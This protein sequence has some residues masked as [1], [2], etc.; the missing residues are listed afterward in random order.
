MT[1]RALI[2]LVAAALAIRLLYALLALRGYVPTTDALHYHML[3]TS[4]A[5]GR[6]LVHPFPLGFDHPTAFRPPLWPLLLGALYAVTGPS[7]GAAQVLTAALGAAAVVGLAL[8][9]TR[10]AGRSAGLAT[11]AVAALH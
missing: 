6:G 4:V 11:G 9:V 2:L 3:A 10:L 8:L 5:E 1:R 7:V